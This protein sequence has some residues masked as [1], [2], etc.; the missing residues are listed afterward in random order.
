MSKSHAAEFSAQFDEGYFPPALTERYIP[1]ELLAQN[2]NGQTFLMEE[3]Q[4]GAQIVAKRFLA[5]DGRRGEEILSGLSHGGIPA[6]I[7]AFR[8]KT[9][10]FL[11]REFVPGLPLDAYARRPLS[12]KEAARIIRELCGILKYLHGQK[13]PVIHR[14]LKPSNVIIDPNSGKIT[15][16]DFGIARTFDKGAAKDTVFMG[17]HEF[18]PPEQYGFAQTDGR[19]DIYALGIFLCWLLTGETH[20]DAIGN[21]ALKRIARRC[22]A[23]DPAKR[24]KNV[25]QVKRDLFRYNK[26]IKG[27]IF[28][29][30]IAAAVAFAFFTGGFIAGRYTD[31]D[32]PFLQGVF[33]TAVVFDD[34][35]TEARVRAQMGVPKGDITIAQAKKIT[36]LDLRSSDP[37]V[38]YE[39]KI[40]NIG[41]LEHFKNLQ[42]LYLDWN[43][44]ED[45]SPLSGLTGLKTLHL[46]GNGGITDYSPLAGLTNM[47]AIM[48]VGC[49][50]TASDLAACAGMT[51]LESFWVESIF[52][53]DIGVVSNFSNLRQLVLK[54]C[55]VRDL[56]PVAALSNLRE[57]DLQKTPVE[58]FSPLLS[59]PNLG[60]VILTGAQRAQAEAQLYGAPFEIEYR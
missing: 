48:F 14:D 27:K 33:E 39:Q 30:V 45:I 4:G 15:L 31:M 19:A 12:E 17:T 57:I 5:G 46:N 52:Y 35:L 11:L 22:A 54:E 36:Q 56:T 55:A 9:H 16:I 50:C 24:Y 43:Q 28:A 32:V 59:L 38:P 21:P 18:S 6:F 44:V 29:A 47:K 3:K 26:K 51:K 10:V 49:Q 13:P 1:L 41:G 53:K 8:T 58:D 34:P 23:F 2:E 25:L 7:E 37:S 20:T 40:K 60:R 42:T